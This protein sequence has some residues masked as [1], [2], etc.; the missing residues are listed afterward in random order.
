MVSSA[1]SHQRS[2]RWG[3]RIVERVTEGAKVVVWAKL[4]GVGIQKSS[5]IAQNGV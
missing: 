4:R 3:F 5:T 1:Q 2:E